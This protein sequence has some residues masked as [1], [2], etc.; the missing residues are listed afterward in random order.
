MKTSGLSAQ[1]NSS[2]YTYMYYSKGGLAFLRS[3]LA[4]RTRLGE[5]R[6]VEGI[7]VIS[8]LCKP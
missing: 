4:I 8:H 6:Y 5:K 2:Q 3:L 7:F 1:E